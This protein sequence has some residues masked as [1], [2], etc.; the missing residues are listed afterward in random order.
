[1]G[2]NR[3]PGRFSRPAQRFKARA[4]TRAAVAF[5]CNKTA[6]TDGKKT[7]KICVCS[8]FLFSIQKCDDRSLQLLCPLL[9]LVRFQCLF[10]RPREP[11]NIDTRYLAA[12]RCECF[13]CGLDLIW[14]HLHNLK[15][16]KIKANSLECS[17]L[18]L[19]P[20]RFKCLMKVTRNN[21]STNTGLIIIFVFFRIFA[22]LF[23]WTQSS[24]V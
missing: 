12:K 22:F 14:I 1:M 21:I 18:F 9:H 15:G 24:A 11:L 19:N 17:L 16:K 2:I 13:Y 7:L 4:S 3:T 8:A 5:S 10:E 20:V 23:N 6:E